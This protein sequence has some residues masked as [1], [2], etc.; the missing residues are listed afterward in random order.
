MES[1]VT[2]AELGPQ[3]VHAADDG[4]PPPDLVAQQRLAELQHRPHREGELSQSSQISIV[5]TRA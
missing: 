5:A 1:C 2:C 3:L 4:E